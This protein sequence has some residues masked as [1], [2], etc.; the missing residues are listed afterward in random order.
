MSSQLSAAHIYMAPCCGFV[1]IDHA[2][3]DPTRVLPR[4]TRETCLG[5]DK[6]KNLMEMQSHLGS[7]AQP[8]SAAITLQIA[9]LPYA[10]LNFFNPRYVYL[11]TKGDP[12]R[13]ALSTIMLADG[14]STTAAGSVFSLFSW[15]NGLRKVSLC[16]KYISR[17]RKLE[18]SVYAL[19]VELKATRAKLASLEYEHNE[20]H[21]QDHDDP[22]DDDEQVA[23]KPETVAKTDIYNAE[24]EAEEDDDVAVPVT[25]VAVLKS[26]KDVERE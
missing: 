25:P 21:V 10:D 24:T 17:K 6:L 15:L 11:T 18:E 23:A 4:C 16:E 20:K 2:H 7:F 3:N 8:A 12:S 26:F 13:V 9:S 19:E 22:L 14:I 5:N 1:Y